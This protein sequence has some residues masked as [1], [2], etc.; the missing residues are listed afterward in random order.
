[1]LPRTG[2]IQRQN[3]QRQQREREHN[4]KIV[5]ERR[6]IRT[7]GDTTEQMRERQGADGAVVQQ[8]QQIRTNA[9][10]QTRDPHSAKRHTA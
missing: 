3:A 9:E 2:A 5:H 7:N 6:Q 10:G 1:M 4:G 8:R